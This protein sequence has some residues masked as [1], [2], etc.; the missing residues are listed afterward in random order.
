MQRKR[1][2]PMRTLA[3]RMVF[4]PGQSEPQTGG[5]FGAC[6]G[7]IYGRSVAG[8]ISD[9]FGASCPD[10]DAGHYFDWAEIKAAYVL[11]QKPQPVQPK[12]NEV[13][14]LIAQ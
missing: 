9:A 2:L 7:H 4:L 5:L 11:A 12:L 13:H 10:L 1:P 3:G 14:R 6:L 8:C